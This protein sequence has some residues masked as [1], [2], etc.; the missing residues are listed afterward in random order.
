MLL[1]L[2]LEPGLVDLDASLRGNFARQLDR[3]TQRCLEVERTRTRK[4][5]FA[6]GLQRRYLGVELV[7]TA[8]HRLVEAPLLVADD[9]QDDFTTLGQLRIHGR[10]VLDHSTR[11]R[12]Q[13]HANRGAEVHATTNQT[14]QDVAPA[15]VRGPDAVVD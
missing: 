14:S 13:R 5:A 8:V 4:H 6:A 2:C 3:E 12:L 11:D 7:S 15:V 10:Y 1:V 9:P